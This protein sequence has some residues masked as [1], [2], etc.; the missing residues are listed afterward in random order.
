MKTK[1]KVYQEN[2]KNQSSDI[3]LAEL[4]MYWILKIIN[5]K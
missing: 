1:I 4:S 5:N 3:M 2:H